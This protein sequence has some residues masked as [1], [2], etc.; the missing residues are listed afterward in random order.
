M[1]TTCS[2]E[3]LV[4]FKRTTR[5]YTPVGR[6]ILIAAYFKLKIKF[7]FIKL[8]LLSSVISTIPAI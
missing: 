6:T 5:R 8:R 2:S 1:D 4:D 7:A 3:T